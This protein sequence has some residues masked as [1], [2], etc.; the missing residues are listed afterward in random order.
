MIFIDVTYC[1]LWRWNASLA[2]QRNWRRYFYIQNN[3]VPS[4]R[5]KFRHG[6]YSFRDRDHSARMAMASSQGR[7][8]CAQRA[9]GCTVII[10]FLQD[11][12]NG[13]LK[14]KF[15]LRSLTRLVFETYSVSLYCYRFEIGY[16]RYWPCAQLLHLIYKVLIAICL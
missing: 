6:V 8:V 4:P 3:A 12:K 13:P 2:I 15:C 7:E 9:A 11:L 5:S 1:R 10:Q 16:N 14:T